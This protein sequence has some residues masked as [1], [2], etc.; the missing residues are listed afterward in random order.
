MA[1]LAFYIGDE[2]N[3]TGVLLLGRIIETLLRGKAKL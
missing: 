1:W 3:A 2:A